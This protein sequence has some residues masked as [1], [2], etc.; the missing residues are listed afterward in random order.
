MIFSVMRFVFIVLCFR[1]LILVFVVVFGM[2][3]CWMWFCS[4]LWIFLDV[5]SCGLL[6][7][8]LC[9]V[10]YCCCVVVCVLIRVVGFGYSDVG[11]CYRWFVLCFVMFVLR[12]LYGWLI[13]VFFVR[14]LYF[15]GLVVLYGWWF[16]DN[17]WLW[18]V[19]VWFFCCY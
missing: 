1:V 10:C 4:L 6:C 13:L 14:L 3:V 11:L 19:Y 17:F 7:R 9:C 18:R 5:R 8:F 16:G 2:V 12:C 15:C